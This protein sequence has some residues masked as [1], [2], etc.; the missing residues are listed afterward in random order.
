MDTA[1]GVMKVQALVFVWLVVLYV[2]ASALEI[3]FSAHRCDADYKNAP[4]NFGLF[5]VNTA[6]YIVI[7][8]PIALLGV[9]LAQHVKPI[10]PKINVGGVVGIVLSTLVLAFAFDFFQY[11][12]HRLQHRVPILW[13]FHR[14]HHTDRAINAST[15]FRRSFGEIM[16]MYA[17]AMIPLGILFGP[18]F[19]PLY[20]FLLFFKGWGYINHLNLKLSFGPLNWLISSP[21][22]HRQHHGINGKYLDCNYAAFF[23]VFDLAFGTCVYPAKDEYPAVGVKNA[24]DNGVIKDALVPF[25]SSK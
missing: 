2:I 7:S 4:H 22:Y 24:R 8:P 12:V 21:Q 1:L 19:V 16:T 3:C 13:K 5:A 10:V 17:G 9:W 14:I 6:A 25:L 20:A 11:W 23:P 18:D 15:E